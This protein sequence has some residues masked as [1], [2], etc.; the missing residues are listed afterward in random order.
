MSSTKRSTLPPHDNEESKQTPSPMLDP[1]IFRLMADGAPIIILLL[2]AQ[3]NIQYVN[4]YFEHLTGYR[5]DEI[6]GNNWFSTFLPPRDQERIRALFRSAIHDLP[7]RNH[8][9]PIIT[10]S[11]EEREIEW[12]GQAM[13]D[14]RG[15]ITSLVSIGQDITARKQAEEALNLSEQRLQLAVQ[16]AHIGIYDH[17]HISDTLYWSAELRDMFGIGPDEMV[18]IERF[19]ERVH[20]EDR[21]RVAEAI[22]HAHSPEGDGSIDIEF[23]IIGRSDE[24][25]WLNA[26]SQTMFEGEGLERRT[27][28]TIGVISDISQ[29]KRDQRALQMMKFSIDHM[30]D[31]VTWINSEAKVLYANIAAC[32]SLGYTHEEM[33]R[34]RVPDFDP[35]FPTEAWP[36]HWDALKKHGSFTFESR[37]RTKDGRI[38]P[39]EV[40]INYMR[41]EDEEYNCG[42]ARDIS[43]R[44]Q[45]EEELRIAATTFDSQDAILIT[46]RDANIL[47]ANQAFQDMSGYDADELIGKNP[48]IIK[49]ERHDADFFQTIQSAL[50]NS[51]KWSGE[52]WACRKNGEDYPT[53]V[54]ITAVYDDHQQVSNYVSVAR[55]ISAIKKTEQEIHQLAFY[56]HLTQLPNR[57]LLL[58]RLQRTIAAS[59]RHGWHGALIFLDLDH[60]KTINDTQGHVMG[61]RLLIEAARR[62]LTC[63]R[64]ID[65]V[66]RLGGD[67]FVV[68]LEELSTQAQ[69]AA[70]QTEMIVEKIRDELSKPYDLNNY[71]Y[72][73]TASFGVNLFRGHQESVED[74]L[75]HADIAMYQ[76]K[77]SGRNVMRFYDP[78]MQAAIEARADLEDELRQALAKQQFCLHY[79]IQV[80][81]Q[82]RPLGAEVLL[83]WEHPKRGLVSPAEFIII[84]EE[85]GLIIPI[86]LW[87]LHT[88]CRQLKA[89]Q[90]NALTR[91]LTLAVNV[92]AKQFRQN[93]F[94]AQV[95]RI[96]LESGAQASH[97]KLELTES[98]V[99]ENVEDTISKMRELKRL[100]VSFSMDDFGTGYSSL[101]YLKRLPLDQIKI[102][103]SFVRDITFDPNDDAIVQT[104]IA[105][106]EALG[107]SVIA[108]G[109]ET[110]TQHAFLE[111]H[112]CHAFQGYLFGK[113]L[114]LAQFED[115]LRNVSE[116]SHPPDGNNTF[117]I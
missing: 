116:D 23:R 39:V 68:V 105:M 62:L 42:Y 79:Q 51:G 53:A 80:D 58:E 114:P 110:E 117:F 66:A 36:D 1:A 44:K 49:S 25:R 89:W 52:I 63:V 95:K 46:D 86:G 87:V 40:S 60:F 61:D 71:D 14:T 84:T 97:L 7:I 72:I 4:P 100:G 113:P 106:T 102:D 31:K 13:R 76:A 108:E 75:K 93:D 29:R 37:H 18:T 11:G 81:K 88:A 56:D 67:E 73:S 24:L 22:N 20:T 27:G 15:N 111:R 5:L 28:R 96:L 70:A 109:V 78:A 12:H 54:T 34:M 10:A 57:R 19:M 26:R 92:S 38:Y 32:S 2:D 21:D 99:L 115:L 91:D 112:D 35:D 17:D 104:I 6:K 94:V 50:L 101:Q 43:K 103:Q 59:A 47:R 30:G 33:L 9:N 3:G 77:T 107:L 55:D 69:E 98:T 85:T 90:H 65:S 48:R 64:E 83:R 82:R 16:S 41:F 8:V 74:L 45:M